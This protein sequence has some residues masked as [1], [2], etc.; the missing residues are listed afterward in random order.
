MFL[1]NNFVSVYDHTVAHHIDWLGV[2]DCYDAKY[3]IER[4]R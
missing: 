2:S 1:E 4:M 3:F